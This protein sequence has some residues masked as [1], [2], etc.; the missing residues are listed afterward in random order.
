M[1]YIHYL[2]FNKINGL[3][4]ILVIIYT[5]TMPHSMDILCKPLN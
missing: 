2:H 1:N 4:D 3:M 5:T